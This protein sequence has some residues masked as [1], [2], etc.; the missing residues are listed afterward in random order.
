MSKIYV[1]SKFENRG[2]V[3]SVMKDLREMGH[4]V[5]SDWTLDNPDADERQLR[6]YAQRDVDAVKA[7][8]VYLGIFTEDFDYKGSL[9]ELGLAMGAGASCFIVGD[10]IDA[11]IF[12]HYPLIQRFKTLPEFWAYEKSWLRNPIPSGGVR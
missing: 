6:D 12:I 9:V 8:N 11:G 2:L 5:M 3:A 1:A 7:C 10:F 4:E